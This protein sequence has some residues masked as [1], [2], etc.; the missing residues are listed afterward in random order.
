LSQIRCIRT[1]INTF[2]V[3]EGT[4]VLGEAKKIGAAGFGQQRRMGGGFSTG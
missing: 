3:P 1:I 4:V 2:I